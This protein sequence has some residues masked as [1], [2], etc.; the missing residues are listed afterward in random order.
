[1]ATAPTCKVCGAAHW[2]GQPH[3]F[4]AEPAPPK[5]EPKAAVKPPV[6]TEPLDALAVY[7]ANKRAAASAYMREYRARK[8]AATP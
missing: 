1:M 5:R 4:K 6:A 2:S 3:A 7:L 8:K